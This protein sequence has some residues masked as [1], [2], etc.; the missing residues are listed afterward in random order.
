MLTQNEQLQLIGYAQDHARA[1]RLA[2]ELLDQA[3]DELLGRRYQ[4]AL[5]RLV[6]AE[7]LIGRDIITQAERDALRGS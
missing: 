7:Q 3:A 6:E 2:G 1:C 5:D 4:P